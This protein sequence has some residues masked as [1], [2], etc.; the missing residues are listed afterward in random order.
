MHTPIY[1][2]L[3]VTTIYQLTLADMVVIYV[4]CWRDGTYGSSSWH[5]WQLALV[6]VH[7]QQLPG[8]TGREERTCTQHVCPRQLTLKMHASSSS[9]P[10]F[11]RT[12]RRFGDHAFSVAAPRAWNL[13]STELRLNNIQASS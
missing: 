9:N 10:L 4:S 7:R 8:M 13:L 2:L 6:C 5:G 12:E 3:V 1:H 11:I